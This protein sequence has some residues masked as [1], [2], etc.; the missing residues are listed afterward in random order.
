M[1]NAEL[2]IELEY[3]YEFPDL[4]DSCFDVIPEVFAERNFYDVCRAGKAFNVL[5]GDAQFAADAGHADEFLLG[6]AG[7]YFAE[8]CIQFFDFLAGH[9]GSLA[10]VRHCFVQSRIGLYGLVEPRTDHCE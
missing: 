2:L 3:I 10:G 4:A 5:L 1:L 7:V 6:G 8:A 9:A